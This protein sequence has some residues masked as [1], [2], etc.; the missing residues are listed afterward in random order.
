MINIH[1][2]GSV[3]LRKCACPSRSTT[4][5]QH[6]TTSWMSAWASPTPKIPLLTSFILCKGNA[7]VITESL[8]LNFMHNYIYVR[9]YIAGMAW[10]CFEMR[11]PHPTL[12]FIAIFFIRIQTLTQLGIQAK[13]NGG[14]SPLNSPH[15]S[16]T[17]LLIF[18]CRIDP[19]TALM[20]TN[21]NT[22]VSALNSLD[23]T[24]NPQLVTALE[25]SLGTSTGRA[26]CSTI[27]VSNLYARV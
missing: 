11:V 15:P 5:G 14:S 24:G 2:E 19:A 3:Q 20:F 8:I 4:Q 18:Y 9:Y 22:A 23:W 1:R 27:G 12:L 10:R 6:I 7:D 17:I 26:F 16:C 25:R 13:N 21:P